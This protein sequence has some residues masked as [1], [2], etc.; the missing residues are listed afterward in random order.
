[1]VGFGQAIAWILSGSAVRRDSWKEG[2]MLRPLVIDGGV[3][4][5]LDVEKRCY[6]H[7][8]P[9]QEDLFATDWVLL[10]TIAVVAS[11]D[12]V[13]AID[14]VSRAFKKV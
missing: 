8:M 3:Q 13:R 5:A 7:W 4:M 11:S 14:V 1:M 12:I 2:R 9:R 6:G 10:E